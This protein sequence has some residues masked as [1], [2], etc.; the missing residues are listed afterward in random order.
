M[1]TFFTNNKKQFFNSKNLELNREN[2]CEIEV[3]VVPD[4][5]DCYL[6]EKSSNDILDL[7]SF[8]RWHSDRYDGVQI[9]TSKE[10]V[11]EMI[12]KGENEQVEFKVEIGKKPNDFLE[13]IVSFA[14]TKGVQSY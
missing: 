11:V 13:S 6:I 10:N 7:K 1:K 3:S 4:T 2:M 8:G 14:N 9:R 12:A 5:I